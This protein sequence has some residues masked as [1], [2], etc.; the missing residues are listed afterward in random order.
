MIVHFM[1]ENGVKSKEQQQKFIESYLHLYADNCNLPIDSRLEAAFEH[2][3]ND[4]HPP[5]NS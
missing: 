2:Y 4:K 5:H 1:A 3:D